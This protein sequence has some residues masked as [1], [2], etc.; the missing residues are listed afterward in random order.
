LSCGMFRN[1][2][3]ERGLIVRVRVQA[4]SY[5]AILREAR[6]SKRC[7]GIVYCLHGVMTAFMASR[8]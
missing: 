5:R 7:V 8:S 4:G 3:S 2:E 6:R 1:S